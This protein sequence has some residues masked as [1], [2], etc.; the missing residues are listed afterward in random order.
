M[1]V[2]TY[3]ELENTNHI[4]QRLLSNSNKPID[5]YINDIDS[6]K[7]FEAAFCCDHPIY[8]TQINDIKN[9]IP[10]GEIVD[11]TVGSY[12]WACFQDAIA[13]DDVPIQCTPSCFKGLK[14]PQLPMCNI[15]IY[16]KTRV[17]GLVFLN[18]QE[19]N[20]INGASSTN[21]TANVFLEH[22]TRFT[23]DDYNYFQQHQYQQVNIYEQQVANNEKTVDT[24][25]LINYKF[26]ETI[27]TSA[28]IQ[29]DVTIVTTLTT[30]PVNTYE[31]SNLWWIW[32]IV[33]VIVVLIVI[34]LG[35][36]ASFL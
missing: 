30:A 36:Y 3:A 2:V 27:Q 28:P 21:T 4:Y 18:E 24:T 17:G 14:N 1:D 10:V 6:S 34:G 31:S 13:I 5:S 25:P 16:N 32:I 33:I 15:P 7:T 26:K 35:L 29:D 11:G 8:E 20:D 23:T 12:L 22:G 19:L 9:E